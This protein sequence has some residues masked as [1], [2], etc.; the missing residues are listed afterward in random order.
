MKRCDHCGKRRAK[1]RL[2][3]DCTRT[4]RRLCWLCHLI[5]CS[6][7]IEADYLNVRAVVATSGGTRRSESDVGNGIERVV[8]A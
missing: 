1:K 3:K 6:E 2:V 5:L 8:G 4:G 7:G